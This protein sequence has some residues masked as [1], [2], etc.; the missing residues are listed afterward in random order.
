MCEFPFV[1]RATLP[2][3]SF[4]NGSDGKNVTLCVFYHN[5]KRPRDTFLKLKSQK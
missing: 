4:M 5:Q 1:L 3:S 2:N